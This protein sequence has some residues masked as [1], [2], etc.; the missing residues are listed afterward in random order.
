MID[1][2]L[3]DR[4]M[5]AIA[6]KTAR[7]LY[8][9]LREE[10]ESP[11]EYVSVK[12]AAHILG[13]TQNHMRRIKNNFPHIKNGQNSQGRLLFKRDSLLPEYAK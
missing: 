7:I 13:I 3:S 10:E 9:K 11:A 8:R 5:E 4:Q 2:T 12:E 6:S 1:I